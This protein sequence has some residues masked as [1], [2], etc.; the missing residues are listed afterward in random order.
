LQGRWSLEREGNKTSANR[1]NCNH[2]RCVVEGEKGG[3]GHG[4]RRCLSVCR[5]GT[6][7]PGGPRGT[8]RL[9][10]AVRGLWAGHRQPRGMSR[11]NLLA[12]EPEEESGSRQVTGGKGR[13]DGVEESRVLVLRRQAGR[14]LARVSVCV[15]TNRSV[16]V[17]SSFS[18]YRCLSEHVARSS[19]PCSFAD[20]AACIGYLG[21][22]EGSFE[23]RIEKGKTQEL[24]RKSH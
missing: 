21:R 2:I 7:S 10:S 17:A 5:V 16:P 13:A 6:P 15:Q 11:W 9:R 1:R 20:A 14:Q 8:W 23:C 18:Y 22:S 19:C 24:N 12:T 4:T 3:G